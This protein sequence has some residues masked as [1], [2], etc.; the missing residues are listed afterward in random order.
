MTGSH[1]WEEPQAGGET[2]GELMK[3]PQVVLLCSRPPFL[4]TVVQKH[5]NMFICLP[6]P[7]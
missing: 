7:I 4:E 5:F 2:G 6:S 1:R 3:R